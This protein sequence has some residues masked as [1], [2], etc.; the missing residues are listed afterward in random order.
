LGLTFDRH[1]RLWVADVAG[2]VNVI[3][4]RGRMETVVGGGSGF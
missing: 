4:G 2:Y 3:D 1:G